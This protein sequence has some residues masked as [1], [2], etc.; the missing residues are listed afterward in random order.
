MNCASYIRCSDWFKANKK[1]VRYH[2]IANNKEK[3]EEEATTYFSKEN[4][5]N[6]NNIINKFSYR[7]KQEE[8]QSYSSKETVCKTK[9]LWVVQ[10]TSSTFLKFIEETFTYK[11]KSLNPETSPINDFIKYYDK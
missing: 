7:G 11:G 10:P 6:I 5:N 9:K 4:S 1:S 2:G 3:E 8:A